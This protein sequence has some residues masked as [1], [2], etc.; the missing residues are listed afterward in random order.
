MYCYKVAQSYYSHHMI[1]SLR[2]SN[3][4]A[5]MLNII[6]LISVLHTGTICCCT[7]SETERSYKCLSP[8]S[9]FISVINPSISCREI[10]LTRKKSFAK[11]KLAQCVSYFMPNKRTISAR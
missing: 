1:S 10:F 7:S 8:R 2:G 6:A 4:V 5:C 9:S 11:L 3:I